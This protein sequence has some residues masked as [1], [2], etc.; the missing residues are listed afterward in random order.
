VHLLAALVF[1]LQ[2]ALPGQ[3][4]ERGEDLGL[5][6]PAELANDLGLRSRR[7]AVVED[8]AFETLPRRRQRS[9]WRDERMALVAVNRFTRHVLQV[10]GGMSIEEAP[11][12]GAE[13]TTH[14]GRSVAVN[15]VQTREAPGC[16]AGFRVLVVELDEIGLGFSPGITVHIEPG[17]H[18]GQPSRIDAR[19][20]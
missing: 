3:G 17:V 4:G 13:D 12:T 16:R 2:D 20:R 5:S 1:G 18:D 14:T 10:F 15:D 6:V 8:L 19:L 9:L 7:L 11:E